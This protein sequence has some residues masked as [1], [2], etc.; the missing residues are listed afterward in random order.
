V[1]TGRQTV[2]TGDELAFLEAPFGRGVL[3]VLH[4]LE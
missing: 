3:H 4:F 1:V 2:S